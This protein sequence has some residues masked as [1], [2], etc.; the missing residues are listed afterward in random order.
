MSGRFIPSVRFPL[1]IEGCKSARL[2]IEP[3]LCDLGYGVEVKL[4]L[5][6]TA[7]HGDD[8]YEYERILCRELAAQDSIPE[9]KFYEV[10]YEYFEGLYFN[11][12]SQDVVVPLTATVLRTYFADLVTK[13]DLDLSDYFLELASPS[14]NKAM[15]YRI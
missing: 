5:V 8:R 13:C 14:K 1:Y 11:K 9:G 12:I 2:Q 10:A 3:I 6:Q 15:G 7:G 4:I